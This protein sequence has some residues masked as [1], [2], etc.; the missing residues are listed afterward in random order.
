MDIKKL[1][2]ALTAIMTV[3]TVVAT[4]AEVAISNV[5]EPKKRRK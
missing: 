1:R 3:A 4:I 2:Q 5:E